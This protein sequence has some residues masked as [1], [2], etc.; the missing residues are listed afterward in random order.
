MTPLREAAFSLLPKKQGIFLRCDRGEALYVTN[1]PARTDER[2]DWDMAGFSCR[3]EG[4]LVFLTPE[5]VWIGRLEQWL[6]IK[7]EARLAAA[8][9]H[10]DFQET[11]EADMA[12][13]IEGV[14]L[15]E[16]QG[17]IRGYEKKVR[18][19]AAVCLREK[20]GGGTIHVC[21]LIADY[22]NGGGNQDEDSMDG[23]RL[24]CGHD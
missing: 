17:D 1:A 4:K 18:Q 22:L 19:R 20:R 7:T 5:A 15:I 21:A 23:T 2:I 8:V 13:L 16:L 6:A 10:A 24:L 11:A 14:K 9:W 3:A 12:L